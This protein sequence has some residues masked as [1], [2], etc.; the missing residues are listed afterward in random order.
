MKTQSKL[1]LCLLTLA[2][3]TSCKKDVT[4]SENSSYTKATIKKVHFGNE[5]TISGTGFSPSLNGNTVT[6]NGIN[7]RVLSATST[8]LKFS[9]PSI[10]EGSGNIMVTTGK[11]LVNAGNINYTADIFVAGFEKNANGI[12]N[13]RYWK[14]GVPV[15]LS[16]TNLP[17]LA[18]D[19]CINDTDIYVSGYE[20]VGNTNM[21]TYWKNGV[22]IRLSQE[23]NGVATSIVVKGNDVYVAGRTY[24]ADGSP[25]AVYWKNGIPVVLSA[26]SS[27]ASGIFLSGNDVYVCGQEVNG[28]NIYVAKYWKNGVPVSLSNGTAATYAQDIIVKGRTVYVT[29]TQF[30]G[31][32]NTAAKYWENGTEVSVVTGN[33]SFAGLA[34]KG[35]AV[36][37]AG[38]I[39]PNGINYRT[40]T[41]WQNGVMQIL[42]MGP[43]YSLA[44]DITV[45]G[46]TIYT[47]GFEE[48]GFDKKISKYW[49]NGT[50]FTLTDSDSY[51]E[52][53]SI[54]VR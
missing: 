21:A 25:T 13:A 23:S 44:T 41:Y 32:G 28:N 53:L 45:H 35:N 24:D 51:S 7:A 14:N 52:A 9:M 40:A 48:H 12:S 54:V 33:S 49:R 2:L 37:L 46:N 20:W 42:P 10:D 22:P 36:Y 18:S 8:H 5:V 30:N 39:Q 1:A 15:V 47:C 19:I 50:E 27:M 11:S 43:V 6:I 16:A 3:S 34:L 29:G 4:L 31:A 26:A 17:S 38:A